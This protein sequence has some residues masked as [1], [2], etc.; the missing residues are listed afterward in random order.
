MTSLFIP[1]NRSKHSDTGTNQSEREATSG[2][3]R[4]ARESRWLPTTRAIAGGVLVGVASL[5]TF[6]ALEHG[7]VKPTHRYLVAAADLPAGHQLT[8]ADLGTVTGD[9][10]TD[11]ARWAFDDVTKVVGSTLGAPAAKGMLLQQ[12]MLNT[13]SASRPAF[14]V[15]LMIETGRFPDALRS[16]DS[17]DVLVTIGQGKDATTKIVGRSVRIQGV[18]RTTPGGAPTSGVVVRL[19]ADSEDAEQALTNAGVLG[20]VTLVAAP[21]D[22]RPELAATSITSASQTTAAP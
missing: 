19:A 4:S 8:R 22:R 6:W 14:E 15:P 11:V 10:P 1:R 13:S 12:P 9:L 7:N 17:V 20:R 5:L 21:A 18:S 2:G 16:G 3:R